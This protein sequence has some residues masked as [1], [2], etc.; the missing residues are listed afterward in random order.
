MK[1]IVLRDEEPPDDT[2]VVLRGGEMNGD[3][4]RRTAQNAHDEYGLYTVSVFL[5]LDED[6]VSL[7][8]PHYDVVLADLEPSTLDRLELAFDRPMVKGSPSP[9]PATSG[10]GSSSFPA[11]S[12]S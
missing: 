11:G 4:V 6:M 3:F 2:V 12:S 1:A 9:R 7:R 8:R 5:V 10:P